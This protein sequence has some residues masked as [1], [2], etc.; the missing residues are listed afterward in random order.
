MIKWKKQLS[1]CTCMKVSLA[2]QVLSTLD[3]Q[4]HYYYYFYQHKY[5][6]GY[7]VILSVN[8]V[9][10]TWNECLLPSITSFRLK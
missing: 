2:R 9:L 8:V 10:Y 4:G 3:V 1:H 7:S 5:K 6:I